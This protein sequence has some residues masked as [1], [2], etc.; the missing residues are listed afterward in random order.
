MRT[1]RSTLFLSLLLCSMLTV[2]SGCGFATGAVVASAG[3]GGGTSNAPAAVTG[4]LVLGARTSPATIRVTLIDVEGDS[5]ELELFY[6]LAADSGIERKLAKV[7][8]NPLRLAASRSGQQHEISWDFASEPGIAAAGF[9]EDVRLI[10]RVVGGPDQVTVVDLGN[11][12]PVVTAVDLGS[13]SGEYSGNTDISIQVSDSAAD[14]V[15]VRIEFNADPDG[16]FPESGWRPVRPAATPST[17]ATPSVGLIGM[18]T[19]AAGLHSTFRW[20]T[21]YDLAGWDDDV[22]LRV[23]ADDRTASSPPLVVGPLRIDNNIAPLVSVESDSFQLGHKDR[24]N[25]PVPL[26]LVDQE[27]DPI[28]VI[29]QWRDPASAWPALP[30]G[31]EELRDLAKNPARRSERQALQIAVESPLEFGGRTAPSLGPSEVHLR[32][33]SLATDAGRIVSMGMASREID[34]LR[35]EG[36]FQP[37]IWASGPTDPV[38]VVLEDETRVVVLDR[39]A[40][41]WSLSRVDLQSGA[42][43]RVLATGSGLPRAL[44]A[45][46]TGDCVF[47]GS[48]VDVRRFDTRSGELTGVVEHGLGDGPRGMAALDRVS[49]LVTGDSR[50]VRCN[51][52]AATRTTIRNGLAEPW[53]V[54]V[55]PSVPGRAYLAERSASRVSILDVDAGLARALGDVAPADLATL[56]PVAFPSPRAI[57]LEENGTR[58]VAVTSGPAGTALRILDLRSP[59]DFDGS[60]TA[61]PF[62]RGES[63]PSV[64]ADAWIVTGPDSM[65]VI[66]T[67]AGTKL[68]SGGVSKRVHTVREPRV[69]GDPIPY[70]PGSQTVTLTASADVPPGSRWRIRAKVGQ[71]RPDGFRNTFLWDTTGVPDPAEVQ[72]RAIPVDGD[73][74]IAGATGLGRSLR[75]RF[76][77]G[78]AITGSGPVAVGDLDGDGDLDVA[79]GSSTGVVVNLQAGPRS[80]T[81]GVTIPNSVA[82][83]ALR[84]V[85]VD[86]DGRL[87][88][89]VP[90]AVLFRTAQGTYQSISLGSSGLSTAVADMDRDGDPDIVIDDG[91]SVRVMAQTAPRVFSMVAS[92]PAVGG[93]QRDLVLDDVDG[94]GAMDIIYVGSPSPVTIYYGGPAW[95]F[96]TATINQPSLGLLGGPKSVCCV[97]LDGD[98]DNDLAVA[99]YQVNDPYQGGIWLATQTS[100]RSFTSSQPFAVDGSPVSIT[101]ADL[102]QDSDI[103]LIV[104]DRFI[105][106]F[107]ASFIRSFYQVRPGHFEEGARIPGFGS[108]NVVAD[109]IDGDGRMDIVTSGRVFLQ[110]GH[111]NWELGPETWLGIEN[112]FTHVELVDQDDD[113]DLDFSLRAFGHRLF[114]QT[115]SGRIVEVSN[116]A[117]LPFGL[118]SAHADFDGDGDTDFLPKPVGAGGSRIYSQIA[119]GVFSAPVTVVAGAPA[120]LA[121]ADLDL[122][123]RPDLVVADGNNVT[124]RAQVVAG[125]FV[126]WGPGLAAP[127]PPTVAIVADMNN[128]AKLDLLL[129]GSVVRVCLQGDAGVF[130]LGAIIAPGGVRLMAIDMNGDAR[131]DVLVDNR[132][133]LQDATGGFLQQSVPPILLTLLAVRD[134]DHDG[135]QDLV[136]TTS[137]G[138]V[139]LRQ[140][141]RQGAVSFAVDSS[142]TVTTGDQVMESADIDGDGDLD[143]FLGG[144]TNR[145]R[146]L[147]GGR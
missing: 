95:A 8:Q 20:D 131:T 91:A 24:G 112:L 29:V 49:V 124:I 45:A 82:D 114:R 1:I 38:G 62:V 21:T 120:V 52:Q 128:D 81:T 93:G 58:L 134:V 35:P 10:A 66:G 113:G 73:V 39:L 34:I 77:S 65:R 90:G 127:E 130:S 61:D 132:I 116:S 28:D 69:A 83:L 43:V 59:L 55:D 14:V 56:G 15:D 7:P 141:P 5:V 17:E 63:V 102:D 22:M 119:P 79:A 92:M 118:L 6:V 145:F 97:D 108:G 64:G 129:G 31:A 76:D 74:G 12:A 46:P 111:R 140:R 139:L 4:L 135:R 11:D 54:A 100:P 41:G 16:G 115:A 13:G 88:L 122:D 94:D 78:V 26:R 37:L 133:Y 103:D 85:D 60:G 48:S 80:F 147:W 42:V 107:E 87:D 2:H 18:A 106:F 126:P 3:G 32:L 40:N 143:L 86:V 138:V 96:T 117:G 109:D 121:T 136:G 27:S 99:N 57:A 23:V 89:V 72:L 84:A 125:S 75:S 25:V 70:D 51:V 101:A 50:I 98:G 44:A 110:A 123:G 104:A 142:F 105:E 19:T 47:V 146:F 53:G 71:S 30:Q 137:G 36:L 68:V 33:P 67:G 9:L 144:I